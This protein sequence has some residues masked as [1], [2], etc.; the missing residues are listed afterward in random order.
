MQQ[1]N[2]LEKAYIKVENGLIA[3]YGSMQDCPNYEGN[4]I[5]L[6]DHWVIPAFVDSHTHM[7]FAASRHN[8]YVMRLQGKTYEDIASEGGGILNSA[9]RL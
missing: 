8:E 9:L 6:S 1:I 5:D 3:E 7:V 4:T 2:K